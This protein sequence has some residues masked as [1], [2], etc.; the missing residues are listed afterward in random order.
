LR[1]SANRQQAKGDWNYPDESHHRFSFLFNHTTLK[2]A[3]F[4][5]MPSAGVTAAIIDIQLGGLTPMPELPRCGRMNLGRRLW[6]L[7]NKWRRLCAF[8]SNGLPYS[9]GGSRKGAKAQRRKGEKP[10][11]YGVI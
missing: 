10:T 4:A 9:G 5:P 8:A 6:S 7:R 1:D 3:V 11:T 2:I